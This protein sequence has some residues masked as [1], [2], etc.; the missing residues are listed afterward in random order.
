MAVNIDEL[1]SIGGYAKNVKEGKNAFTN[2][3]NITY[4]NK[5]KNL[6]RTITILTHYC[7]RAKKTEQEILY[8]FG[9]NTESELKSKFKKFFND[10]GLI[11]FIGPKFYNDIVYKYKKNYA[12]GD[13]DFID[14]VE[15][16]FMKEV[17]E[18]D[19][20]IINETITSKIIRLLKDAAKQGNFKITQGGSNELVDENNNLLLDKFSENREK[21][22]RIKYKNFKNDQIK[23]QTFIKNN[24][25][26]LKIITNLNYFEATQG[27][28]KTE[29]TEEDYENLRKVLKEQIPIYFKEYSYTSYKILEDML[30]Q[31][32][33]SFF[34]GGNSNDIIGVL[35]EYIVGVALNALIPSTSIQQCI[36]WSA[37]EA[38]D[39]GQISSDFIVRFSNSV[40]FGVQVKNT[41]KDFDKLDEYKISFVDNASVSTIFNRL[42]N[43][44]GMDFNNFINAY[45]SLIISKDFNVPYIYYTDKK[46][47]Q[48]IYKEY[49]L[50]ANPYKSYSNNKEYQNIISKKNQGFGNYLQ[51]RNS[52]LALL[53]QIKVFLASFAPYFLYMGIDENFEGG[54][55]NLE[56]AT[57]QL[58]GGGN[59]LY[60]VAGEPF[61]VSSMLQKIINELKKYQQMNE[62]TMNTFSLESTWIS[63]NKDNSF[64]GNIV[65]YKNKY[66]D[67]KTG[68]LLDV[69]MTSSYNFKS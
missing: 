61:F 42:S 22:L 23:Q 48:T 69:K 52:H 12:A 53:D 27:K 29:A 32:P 7:E 21:A 67:Q 56:E 8:C 55:A 24:E 39:R 40:N 60:L 46:T 50:S 35:G 34:I 31:N 65:D 25:T 11:S 9:V 10:S 6:E 30:M 19:D 68:V 58:I 18:L 64:N 66:G 33:E 47:G 16:H 45:S 4:K 59:N 43:A 63:Q 62:Y 5:N 14:Y 17:L 36:Q 20:E 37:K 57:A 13:A 15:N 49:Q 3:S 44:T 38:S 28:K 1:A 54:L 41:G 51:I 2:L 26:K